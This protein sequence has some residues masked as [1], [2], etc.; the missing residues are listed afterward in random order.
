[1]DAIQVAA[2]VLAAGFTGDE[3]ATMVAII[4]GESGDATQWG[5]PNAVGDQALVDEKWGP[6]IGLAQVRSLHAHR[7]T[8]QTRDADRLTDPTFNLASAWEISNQGRNFSPWSVY[9]SGKYRQWLPEA[10]AAVSFA[11]GSGTI[12]P[13]T[14]LGDPLG[15]AVAPLAGDA[16]GF[17]AR[18]VL[19]ALGL[20][21]LTDPAGRRRAVMIAAGLVV[22]LVGIVAVMNRD[23]ADLLS[24]A[25]RVG[26]LDGRRGLNRRAIRRTVKSGGTPLPASTPEGG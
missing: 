13:G 26:S 18:Q 5:N 24:Q 22:A 8:G 10:R 7:G 11:V 15:D 9:S 6:S 3:A 21:W 4:R 25:R 12:P 23:P 20:G 16:A 17:A 1:M 19:N 14:Q 2:T